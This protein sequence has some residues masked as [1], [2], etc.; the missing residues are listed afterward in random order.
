MNSLEKKRKMPRKQLNKT[1]RELYSMW[2]YFRKCCIRTSCSQYEGTPYDK[3]WLTFEGFI[4]ENWFRYLRAKVK[5]KNY[6]RVA[7]KKRGETPA[8]LKI[9][10]IRLKRKVMELG[11]TKEN[12][13]FT[14]P[15]DQMKYFESTHTYMFEG[16]MLGTRD[17]K[18]ILKKRGIELSMEQITKRLNSGLDLFA[19]N[20]HAKIKW[21]GKYRSYVEIAQMEN[22]QFDMLKKRN[23]E[24][25]DIRKAL[26]YCRNWDGF[27]T[28]EFEGKDLRKFEICSILSGRTGIAEGTIQGR[29]T[30]FGMNLPFLIAPLG[31]KLTMRKTIYAIKDGV[32]QKFASI[33]MASQKLG[34]TGANI[35]QAVNGKMV[36]CGGYKFRFEGGQ[37]N[38]SPV[39]T[40]AEQMEGARQI[41]MQK[42][43]E[44]HASAMRHCEICNKDK[45]A[46]E[47]NRTNFRRCKE[48]IAKEKGIVHVGLHLE[49]ELALSKGLLWC[50]DCKEYKDRDMFNKGATICRRHSK[51]RARLAKYHTEEIYQAQM[52]VNSLKEKAREPLSKT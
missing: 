41:L 48:C 4:K 39:L 43:K 8:P 5:W 52:A 36:H 21:K 11:F 30:K 10:N 20:N 15:S 34:L 23:Y 29:F 49:R 32:E 27:M 7:L 13:V 9:N 44:R 51:E 40:M 22:V 38:T 1:E 3:S 47:F 16:Q 14:S 42:S 17:I 46:K 28:Y 45:S 35:S 24:I 2:D 19:E 6:K 50:S 33:E 26:D 18:N 25:N 12:T 37:Y 31:A